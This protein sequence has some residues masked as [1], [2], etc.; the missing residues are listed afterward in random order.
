MTM[1]IILKCQSL[2]IIT[3]FMSLDSSDALTCKTVNELAL[4]V[5]T[6]FVKEL[7]IK[8]HPDV[9]LKCYNNLDPIN[10]YFVDNYSVIRKCPPKMIKKEN[11]M[12]CLLKK[13]FD[14]VTNL[15]GIVKSVSDES[16]DRSDH[17]ASIN[18][19][20]LLLDESK[21]R[22]LFKRFNPK[23]CE[24]CYYDLDPIDKYIVDNYGLIINCR[25]LVKNFNEGDL[26]SCF[27]TKAQNVGVMA[28]DHDGQLFIGLEN[29]IIPS[30]ICWKSRMI[31]FFVL[32]LT[33][34][35]ADDCGKELSEGRL[36]RQHILLTNL[37]RKH[38]ITVHR[39]RRV[40]DKSCPNH[41]A[42]FCP[43]KHW[44][45]TDT[46]FEWQYNGWKQMVVEAPNG[47]LS[48]F[49]SAIASALSITSVGK[50]LRSLDS[51]ITT[52]QMDEDETKQF[53]RILHKSFNEILE[54]IEVLPS[55]Q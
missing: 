53:L 31:C 43:I 36:R 21:I 14:L 11:M 27:D 30:V 22:M 17:C 41:I 29:V 25:P 18:D 51:F 26:T 20:V 35:S 44:L 55:R 42:S 5:G 40:C 28:E 7:V 52:K 34:V 3:I 54:R 47:M 10:K 23:V 45:S 19:K 8:N 46:V 1:S 33:T 50:A 2:S 24:S 4:M 13:T 6:P 9:C 32:S 38:G 37:A 15:I 12:S 48:S 16:I 49:F 39:G